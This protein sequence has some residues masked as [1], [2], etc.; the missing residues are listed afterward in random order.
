VTGTSGTS[1]GAGVGSGVGLGSPDGTDAWLAAGEGLEAAGERVGALPDT[2][3]ATV[4]PPHPNRA[5]TTN[6][7]A[8]LRFI[9]RL[10]QL[11]DARG[12]SE[13]RAIMARDERYPTTCAAAEIAAHHACRENR[14]AGP[15]AGPTI[16]V[17][18]D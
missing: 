15:K 3:G 13:R 4:E 17:P 7:E 11:S 16:V 10:P 8:S 5:R 9:L 12:R 14:R 18:D 1:T 2:T 6:A